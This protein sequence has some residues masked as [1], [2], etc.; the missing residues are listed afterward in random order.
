M[1]TKRELAAEEDAGWAP[2]L[3]IVESLL[4]EEIER[5]GYYPE[6]WSVKD[7]LGHVGCWQAEAGRILER[8]INGTYE[9]VPVDVDALNREFFECNKDLP[10]PIVRAELWSARTRMLMGWN[11]LPEITREAEEWFR[12]SGPAHYDEHLGRLREWASELRGDSS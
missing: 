9:D 3:E 1:T 8:I 6:G 5:P 11:G 4:P 7:L 2:F 12:E 10:V